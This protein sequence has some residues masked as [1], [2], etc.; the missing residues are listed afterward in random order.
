MRKV[1]LLSL[2]ALLA[3][4]VAVPALADASVI[5]NPGVISMTKENIVFD[6]I[7]LNGANQYTVDTADV[8]PWT[9]ND[10]TGL[11]KGWTVSI[12]AT[13]FINQADATKTIPL[14]GFEAQLKQTT[15]VAG[16]GVE[17]ANPSTMMSS[18]TVL[19][20]SDQVMLKADATQGMGF[21]SYLPN[22]KLMVPASTY[23]GTYKSTVEVTTAALP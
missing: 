8:T 19:T 18:L 4:G 5:I 3:I 23:A 1:A 12:N 2:L 10:P 20:G 17:A 16:P 6:A 7:T 11:G 14:T 13:D 21:Y 22:F 9:A 15:V